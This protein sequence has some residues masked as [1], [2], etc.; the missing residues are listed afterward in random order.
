MRRAVRLAWFCGLPT[1]WL[2]L[3]CVGCTAP[4]A[5]QPQEHVV[6]VDTVIACAKDLQPGMPADT[7]AAVVNGYGVGGAGCELVLTSG[8]LLTWIF[9]GDCVM[10]ADFRWDNDSRRT[11]LDRIEVRVEGQTMVAKSSR[12][13]PSY[14]GPR[15]GK[16][17]PPRDVHN[18][19]PILL[20]TEEEG[21]HP[22]EGR[23]PA[24]TRRQIGSTPSFSSKHS[25]SGGGWCSYCDSGQMHGSEN[26]IAARPPLI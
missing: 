13:S 19:M 8:V 22:G 26:S 5:T 21:C 6:S 23:H 9:P 12:D 15:T 3:V 18:L 11:L 2:L 14:T 20:T 25:H 10:T 1:G 4:Q 7:V 24:P 16:S 17:I